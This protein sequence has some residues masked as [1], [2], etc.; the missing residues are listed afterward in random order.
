MLA[1]LAAV[2]LLAV[3]LAP[4]FRDPESHLT[5]TIALPIAFAAAALLAATVWT[6]ERTAAL[7]WFALALVGQAALL[8]L[9]AAGPM[10]GYQ[11]LAA[12][13]AML[14]GTDAVWTVLLLVQTVAVGIALRRHAARLVRWLSEHWPRWR[15]VAVGLG[16]VATSAAVSRSIPRYVLELALASTLQLV[17]LAT[18]VV[19]ATAIPSDDVGRMREVLARWL[20]D[21]REEPGRT[22]GR[23]D[24]VALAG[25]AWA[26]LICTVLTLVVYERHPHVPDE[27]VYLYHARYF[28]D[29]LLAMPSPPVAAAFELDLM[30]YEPDR[31]YSPVPPGW[32]A[33]L[34]V[35]AL[36]GVPWLVNPVLAGIAVLLTHVT[37]ARLY[38]MRTARLT[39]VFLCTSPWFLF[40]GMNF[41]TH[42]FALVLALAGAWSIA[43]LHGGGSIAW[44]LPAGVA[45]GAMAM[46]RP[47]EA[48]VTALL[49][50]IWVLLSRTTSVVRRI[51][52]LGVL[53]A[54]SLLT[55]LT[56]FPY[57]AHFTGRPTYFPLM[58]Y[59]DAVY[60]KGTNA[61]G[62]GP[63]RG[64]GWPGLDPLPGHGLVDVLINTNLNL[65]QLNVELL[66]WAT[67]SVLL[68]ILAVFSGR[69]ARRDRA[70]LVA[71][72]AV[73]GAHAFYWFSG[74]PDFGAR[75][76]YLVLVP[77]LVL[78]VRGLSVLRERLGMDGPRAVVAALGLCYA[79]I[80]V[81][82]PWR[83]ADKYHDYRGMRPDV[84]RLAEQYDFG[85][86]LVLVRGYRFPD[87]ASA[88]IYNPV[89]LRADAPIYAWDRS[90]DVRRAIL[91]EYG[92][93]PVWI[94]EGPSI[95]RKGFRVSAG[96][97]VAPQASPRFH[98]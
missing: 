85:R 83:A 43:R 72:G 45:T 4:P 96:P 86:S 74:G 46:V 47:L 54:S 51:V 64:L 38:N 31:W 11:H 84:R 70:M 91:E 33:V 25:A 88:A 60:G 98:D 27:V 94:L 95:T 9:T 23:L 48:L 65:F 93:R 97:M 67:G 2:G 89:D 56:V 57:N 77:C 75:Y 3:A 18:I 42:T 14:E 39:T 29:G 40:M 76:W 55:V 8:Q 71:I 35:G 5:G 32:P 15:L 73:V 6:V 13:S 81:F 24:P 1:A 20:P 58:A 37:V 87:Y 21:D 16:F 44:T 80:V 52:A 34:A 28:A 69:L 53:G 26:V 36:F 19:A 66:G 49:L 90:P 30:T 79:A 10:V 41:M 63:E 92:D 59:T 12:R 61:L 78:A 22:R 68:I 82:V 17:A 7:G 62:F 50:G